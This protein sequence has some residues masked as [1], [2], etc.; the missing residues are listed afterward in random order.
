MASSEY[1]DFCDVYG[2]LTKLLSDYG[3]NVEFYGVGY[4]ITFTVTPDMEAQG[5]STMFDD[6]EDEAAA[7]GAQLRL[8]FQDSGVIVETAQRL[9]MPEE[10]LNKVKSLAKKAHYL[11]LQAFFRARM[12]NTDNGADDVNPPEALPESTD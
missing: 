7:Y 5:R 2:K 8:I 9:K 4:P 11:F 1:S 6:E 10:L 12:T 3:Y